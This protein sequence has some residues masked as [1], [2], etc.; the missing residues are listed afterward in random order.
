VNIRQRF[1]L[2]WVDIQRDP[3]CLVCGDK[4]RLTAEAEMS[5]FG[6]YSRW[7]YRTKWGS[8]G[9]ARQATYEQYGFPDTAERVTPK[10]TLLNTNSQKREASNPIRKPSTSPNKS[11]KKV[12][13][14]EP[15]DFRGLRHAPINEQGVVYLFGI[16][17]HELGFLIESVRIS[18]PD[19][20]GK[21]CVDEKRQIWERTLIKFEFKS[22]N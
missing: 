1:C 7:A 17:S 4:F 18:Y 15:L 11:P 2:L 9:V 13:Y 14:G 21:R 16:V 5:A 12:Q 8:F 10:T 22:S 20:G 3:D 19:C 6:N